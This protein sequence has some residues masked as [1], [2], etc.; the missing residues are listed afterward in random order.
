MEGSFLRRWTPELWI[1]SGGGGGRVALKEYIVLG[2]ILWSPVGGH[3]HFKLLRSIEWLS[4]SGWVVDW[5]AKNFL[6]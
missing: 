3:Y 6:L 5:Y 1:F 2:S 4:Q